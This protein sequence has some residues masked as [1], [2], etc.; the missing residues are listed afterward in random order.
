MAISPYSIFVMKLNNFI[1]GIL[2][3]NAVFSKIYAAY[4]GALPSRAVGAVTLFQS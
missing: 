1:T 2:E 3:K 4:R